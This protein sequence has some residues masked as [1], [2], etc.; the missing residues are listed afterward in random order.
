MC[1]GFD[2][3]PGVNFICMQIFALFQTRLCS[4]RHV[5]AHCMT[6]LAVQVNS[7]C[8]V[9]VRY[10]RAGCLNNS[11]QA[12]RMIAPQRTCAP[13]NAVRFLLQS[14][15]MT[16]IHKYTFIGK[17]PRKEN[18]FFRQIS[19]GNCFRLGEYYLIALRG[20]IFRVV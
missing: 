1:I 12:D 18:P 15:L 11:S 7:F 9:R 16:T 13:C 5:F 2:Q 8:S 17:A 10:K 3:F 19:N 4:A 20:L 14:I 6:H